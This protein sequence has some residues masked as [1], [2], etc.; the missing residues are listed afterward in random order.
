MPR[1]DQAT[2]DQEAEATDG[3]IVHRGSIAIPPDCRVREP[4]E[5][6]LFLQPTTSCETTTAMKKMK[7]GLTGVDLHWQCCLLC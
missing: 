7:D 1:V 4:G 2:G 6:G 3:G 5:V